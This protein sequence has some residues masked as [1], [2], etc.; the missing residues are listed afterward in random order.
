M[1]LHEQT[2]IHHTYSVPIPLAHS[3]A[4][5]LD[6]R[7]RGLAAGPALVQALVLGPGEGVAV[8][9]LSLVLSEV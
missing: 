9:R 7:V 6:E 3:V 1:N 4:A 5:T 8:A 2:P